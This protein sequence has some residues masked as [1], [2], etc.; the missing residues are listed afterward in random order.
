MAQEMTVAVFAD[1]GE[2]EYAALYREVGKLLR[3]RRVS[4]VLAAADGRYPADIVA[5]AAGGE[6]AVTLVCA[7]PE[8]PAG[9]PDRVAVEP[10]TDARDAARFAAEAAD[11]LIGLPGGVASA[12]ALYRAWTD[13]G[14]PAS[15][16]PVGLLNR[17]KAFEI[18]RGFI[19]DVAA[20]GLGST[21]QMIVFA[22]GVDDLLG[23]LKRLV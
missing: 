7:E 22:D 9:L 8:R 3:N 11:A 2:T 1:A 13:V 17:K 15:G 10:A 6:A 5:G 21:D 20:P 12:A 14:G 23:K 18:V 4:V 19:S 16:K